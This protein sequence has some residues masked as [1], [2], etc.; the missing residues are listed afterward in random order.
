MKTWMGCAVL[1]T[2]AACGVAAANVADT[3]G[4]DQ[5]DVA[6]TVYNNGLGFVK[7]TRQLDLPVGEVTLA[8]KDVAE[9]IKPETV[10]LRSLTDDGSLAVLEQNYEYDLMSPSKLME[11]YVGKTLRLVSL[12][13]DHRFVSVE[14]ELLSMNEGPVYRVGGDIYLGHPG[15]VVL[16]DVPE[17]L[18]ATPTLVWMLNN[19]IQNQRVELS[20]LTDGFHWKADYVLTLARDD[21][22]MDMTGWVTMDNRSGAAYRDAQLKLVAG[23]VHRAP[24]FMAKGGF[25]AVAEDMAMMRAAPV[26]EAFGD[27]HLYTMPR[28]TTIGRNQS[29]QLL[30]LEVNG[31]TAEKHYELPPA[32]YYALYLQAPRHVQPLRDLRPDVYLKFMNREDNNMGM[33]LPEGVIRVYQEDS[34]GLLQ[35]AGEDRIQHTPR[36]EEVRIKTGKAFDIVAE[37]RQ[38]HY[39]RL[40]DRVQEF[41]IEIEVRNHKD[42]AISI[43]VIEQMGGDWRIVENSHEFTERDAHTLVFT[44]EVP[45]RDKTVISYEVRVQH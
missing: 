11:K 27:F 35:F 38:T 20:Y 21:R 9:R 33:P 16:P 15:Q 17:D 24:D 40:S 7:D 14:A 37:R 26:Q 1:L 43:D 45:A 12:S 44:V 34:E 42:A 19:T 22:S 23:D 6:V 5:T 18:Y 4:D 31:A 32:P 2:L 30:L 36:D 41:G 28:R 3:A 25:G 29:K 8:F 39:E 13:S 10:N